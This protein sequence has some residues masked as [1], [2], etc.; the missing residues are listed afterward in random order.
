MLWNLQISRMS[1]LREWN[2]VE[3]EG[4][5]ILSYWRSVNSSKKHDNRSGRTILRDLCGNQQYSRKLTGDRQTG[6]YYP[7]ELTS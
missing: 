4:R 3:A 2:V 1:W 5:E 7:R 6:D